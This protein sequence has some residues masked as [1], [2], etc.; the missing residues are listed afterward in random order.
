[1]TKLNELKKSQQEQSKGSNLLNKLM[2]PI[3]LIVVIAL[4]AGSIML[5]LPKP[6]S[7]TQAAALANC[8]TENGAKMYGTSTCPDC[9][10]QK[11]FFGDAFQ[12]VNYVECFIDGEPNQECLDV[13]IERFP[14][15]II[16]GVKYTGSKQLSQLAELSGCSLEVE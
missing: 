5:F 1:M 7:N 3:V 13:E 6:V 12:F 15:W 9:K 2:L 16:D 10:R 14:T 8:L 11:A 4:V